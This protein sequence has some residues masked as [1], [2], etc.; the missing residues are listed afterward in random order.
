MTSAAIYGQVKIE[1]LRKQAEQARLRKQ[2]PQKGWRR[3]HSI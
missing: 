1:D 3:R 2:A